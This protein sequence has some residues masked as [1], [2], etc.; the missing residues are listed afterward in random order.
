MSL[1]LLSREQADLLQGMLVHSLVQDRTLHLVQLDV[2]I[3]ELRNC[4]APARGE[5]LRVAQPPQP[6]LHERTCRQ[7]R[8]Q[9]Q[10]EGRRECYCKSL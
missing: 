1:Q 3:G 2:Q 10:S 4:L 9:P 6:Q 8:A 5:V 7:W